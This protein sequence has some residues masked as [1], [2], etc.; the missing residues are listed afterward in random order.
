MQIG[1]HDVT[2]RAYPEWAEACRAV[3]PG[4]Y[5]IRSGEADPFNEV[6]DA[7]PQGTLVW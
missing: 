4:L 3:H 7:V 6:P 1:L 2:G 5:R